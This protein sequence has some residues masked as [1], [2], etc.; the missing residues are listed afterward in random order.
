MDA[1]VILRRLF[2]GLCVIAC[3]TAVPAQQ[4]STGQGAILRMLDKV[5]G[6][7]VDLEMTSGERRQQGRLTITLSECRFPSG[8]PTG[9]AY[10]RMTIEEQGVSVPN[11]EG[12]MVA[13]A[14]ALNPMEHPRY[15]VWVLR[16][17]SS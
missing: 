7:L 3:A 10:A 12:W 14:P 1:R 6:D 5:T 9:D 13:S 17:I 8:N 15:D 4:V 11:F 2:A 16:C